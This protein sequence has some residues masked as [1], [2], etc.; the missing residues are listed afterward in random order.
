MKDLKKAVIR[1]KNSILFLMPNHFEI[2]RSII[3]LQKLYGEKGR[4]LNY[5]LE[6]AFK[7]IAMQ[8]IEID[9][10]NSINSRMFE[11][12]YIYICFT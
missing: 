6:N 11:G 12:I 4:K 1:D 9:S 8:F 7:A 5:F 10:I 2:Y 3:K